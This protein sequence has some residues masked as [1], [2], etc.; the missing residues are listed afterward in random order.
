ME[1]IGQ[2]KHK[3]LK[4]GISAIAHYV[5]TATGTYLTETYFL[6]ITLWKK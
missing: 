6:K 2:T 3:P 4:N 1:K 5:I